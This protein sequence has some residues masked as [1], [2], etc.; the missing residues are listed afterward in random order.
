M[1]RERK[2]AGERREEIIVTALDLAAEVGPDR[3]TTEAIAGRIGLTQAAVFR[4]FPRK[5]DIWVA[6]IGW[7]RERLAR[8]WAEALGGGGPPSD[9]LRTLLVGQFRFIAGVPALPAVLLSRELQAEGGIVQQA[10]LGVMDAFRLALSGVVREGQD[11]GE[12]R[13]GI[14]DRKSTRLNSSHRT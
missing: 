1:S 14:E 13:A 9:K 4:H 5:S 8:R 10:I 6:V 3:I 2:P 11:S 7:L 12:I